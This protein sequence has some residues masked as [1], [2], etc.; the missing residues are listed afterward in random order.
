M[1]RK[2]ATLAMLASVV[3]MAGCTAE[4][5]AEPKHPVTREYA[6]TAP[7]RSL[8]VSHA[9][10]VTMSDTATRAT[11]T[12]DSSLVD[13]L[14][15]AVK[16][17]ELT[18]GFK[19]GTRNVNSISRVT[20]PVNTALRDIDLSGA[21]AFTSDV[22]LAATDIDC[23]GASNIDI[24]VESASLEVDRSGAS[25]ATL[26]GSVAKLD[27]DVSGASGLKAQMLE[28]STVEIE[29]S[30]ASSANVT[31]CQSIEAEVSGASS[32]IYSTTSPDCNPTERVST[33]GAS[34]ATRR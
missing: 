9:F 20:I 17:G 5:I 26:A 12:L 21:S 1:K 14:V 29:V 27:A 30:G 4:N 22:T 18:I 32:L 7:Y 2:I 23:S 3:A 24:T 8:E 25:T 15:F 10:E 31:C 19:S 11:V 34:T 33:S 6:I 13:R 16:D 28:A